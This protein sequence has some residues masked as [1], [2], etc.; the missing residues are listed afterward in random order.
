M[1]PKI[2]VENGI[3]MVHQHFMLIEP[4]SV[5]QNIVLGTEDTKG[6]FIDLEK[7]RKKVISII[8]KYGFNID[9]DEKFKILQLVLNKRLKF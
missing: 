5:I 8:E 9:L 3:G 1:T 6:L 4:F 7:S 2:A